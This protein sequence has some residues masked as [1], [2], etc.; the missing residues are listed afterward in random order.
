[1]DPSDPGL[2][3]WSGSGG[4]FD[5]RSGSVVV[6]EGKRCSGAGRIA[7]EGGSSRWRWALGGR[8]LG[9]SGSTDDLVVLLLLPVRAVAGSGRTGRR[10]S[11]LVWY[12]GRWT[13]GMPEGRGRAD[14]SV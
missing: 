2:V 14:E 6:G 9:G 8:D 11:G 1:M 10:V 5:G 7:V 13:V 12:G 4:G 3:L